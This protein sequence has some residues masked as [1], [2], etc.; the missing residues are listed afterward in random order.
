[1]DEGDLE[2]EHAAARRCI[3]QLGSGLCELG[4]RGPDVADLVGDVV[5]AGSPPRDEAADGRVLVERF[6]QLDTTLAETHQRGLDTLLLDARAVLEAGTEQPSVRIEGSIEI[7]DRE[8]DVM[9]GAWGFHA[10]IVC[11]RIAPMRASL[12]TLLVAAALLAGCGGGGGGGGSTGG[13][14]TSASSNGEASKSPE[15]VLTDAKTVAAH[16]TSVRLSGTVTSSGQKIGIDITIASSGSAKGS[17]TLGGASVQLVVTGG[18]AYIK[19]SDAFY[20]QFAG[21]AGA[22]A[23][24]L[25]HGKWLEGSAT[26]GQ[27]KSLADFTSIDQLF[28]QVVASHGTLVNKGETTYQG[29]QAVAIYSKTK[30]GTLYVAATGKPYPI[31][32]VGA[33]TDKGSIMF[34]NWN[35]NVSITAP[36]GAIN[37]SQLGG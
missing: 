18:N 20:K 31:A 25:L 32:L 17:M 21:A 5:H 16:A 9:D 23:A 19:A 2:T 8:P 29:Q 7:L 37:I 28:S 15:Q 6:Q 35:A 11:E 13:G 33:G 26:S 1:M 14:T 30:K 4:E 12:L 27:L 22:A 10:A 3:D 36:S 24:Q 34:S